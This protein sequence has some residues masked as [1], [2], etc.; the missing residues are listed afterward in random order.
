MKEE[1]LLLW[2]FT[3]IVLT[4][5]FI[6]FW[7]FSAWGA[8]GEGLRTSAVLHTEQMAGIIN[9]LNN[10]PVGTVQ[11]YGLPAASC[12]VFFDKMSVRTAI[13]QQKG[14]KEYRLA[15][16]DAPA[17][18]DA[19]EIMN[20][21]DFCKAV[22]KRIDEKI[23]CCSEKEK[24]V[25]YFTRCFNDIKIGKEK[26]S[27]F[28]DPHLCDDAYGASP[29]NIDAWTKDTGA[30]AKLFGS[31]SKEKIRDM[32][33]LE[34]SR[35]Y[36]ADGSVYIT[37]KGIG[38][39]QLTPDVAVEPKTLCDP[40]ENI[41]AAASHIGEMLDAFADYGPDKAWFALAAYKFGDRYVERYASKGER[42][43]DVRVR[44]TPEVRY[45]TEA[46]LGVPGD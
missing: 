22:E 44:F 13:Y 26:A 7:G 46:L 43:I 11:T 9:L 41:Q 19:Q 45:Y 31:A 40:E 1:T 27:C 25:L 28:I 33:A 12:A 10:A 17:G 15:V 29:D 39:M 3:I 8:A 16:M 34:G 36:N 18:I 2:L 38:I 30:F 21:E 6:A 4:L 32:L 23:V 35:H 24:T 37:N 14:V 42:W 5:L 20:N